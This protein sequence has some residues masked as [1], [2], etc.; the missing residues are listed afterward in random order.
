MI[1]RRRAPESSNAAIASSRREVP[2]ETVGAFLALLQGGLAE[3]EIRIAA[4]LGQLRL[5]AE[6]P[7]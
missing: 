6:S 3:E 1:T 5:G 2:A 7:E 4:H